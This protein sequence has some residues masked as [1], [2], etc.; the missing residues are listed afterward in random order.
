MTLKIFY[1]PIW[2]HNLC[3]TI[4]VLFTENTFPLCY[5]KERRRKVISLVPARFARFPLLSGDLVGAGEGGE[6]ESAGCLYSF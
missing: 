5:S 3:T 6:A 4:Y 1:T 2:H